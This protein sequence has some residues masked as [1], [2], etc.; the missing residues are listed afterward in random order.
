M[1][2]KKGMNPV[3]AGII[4]AAAGLAVGATAVALS[5]KE[6]RKKIGKGFEKVKEMGQEAYSDMKA[7]VE[8]VASQGE[9]KVEEAKKTVKSKL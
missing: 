8:D 6:N 9:A 7:K 2:N 5:S 1:A 3:E 4:G